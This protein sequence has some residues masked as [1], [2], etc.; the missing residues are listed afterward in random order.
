M[1]RTNHRIPR[2]DAAE[3]TVHWLTALS[4]LYAALTGLALWSYKL[5]WIAWVFGGGPTVREMHPWGGL[6]FAVALGLMAG[7]WNRQMRLSAEDGVW[8]R[9]AHRY[10][11]HDESGLPEAGRF[12][13]GQKSLFWFQIC[14]A[15]L[16]LL[17]GIVLWWPE[18]MPR[19]LRLA[20]VLVHPLAAIAAIGGII[21]HIYMG[22]AAVPGA[23]RGMIQGWVKP[24]WARSHHPKWYRELGSGPKS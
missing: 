19:G 16:L 10:A 5:Y 1:N 8:L 22:T 18:A 20:A 24:G 17:S 12:N 15:S 14:A 9:S 7:R 3:R 2:F 6:V 13:A 23:F 4:F 11:M 21:V